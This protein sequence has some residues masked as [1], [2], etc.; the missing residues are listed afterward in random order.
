MGLDV[1]SATPPCRHLVSSYRGKFGYVRYYVRAVLERPGQPPLQCE[2]EFEVEE[3]LDV[4]RPDL[5]VRRYNQIFK[6]F[7][8]NIVIISRNS[9]QIL[10][11]LVKNK[12]L[13]QSRTWPHLHSAIELLTQSTE[14]LII[15]W[16]AN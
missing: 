5:L 12:N 8:F 2:R 15:Y 3:P 7:Q 10:S 4:N 14:Q 16:L 13:N 9:V 6:C 1:S 11:T